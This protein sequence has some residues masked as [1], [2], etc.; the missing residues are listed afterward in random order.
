[1]NARFC[2][3]TDH[4]SLTHVKIKELTYKGLKNDH[5]HLFILYQYYKSIL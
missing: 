5:F 1:M 2:E 4:N 3:Y